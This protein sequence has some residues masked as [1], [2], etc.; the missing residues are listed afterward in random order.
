MTKKTIPEIVLRKIEVSKL[1]YP[2]ER[3]LQRKL[4]KNLVSGFTD[5]KDYLSILAKEL[6]FT[7]NIVEAKL[8]VWKHKNK[9]PIECMFSYIENAMQLELFIELFNNINEYSPTFTYA[10]VNQEKDGNGVFDIFRFSK[11]SYLEH[12]NRVKYS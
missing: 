6:N 10:F 4:A 7:Q 9:A 12:C 3:K 8:I 1:F 2:L 5:T 11:F